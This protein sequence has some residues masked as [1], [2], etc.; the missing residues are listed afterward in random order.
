MA[1]NSELVARAE[2]LE[3]KQKF[4][5][6]AELY[7]EA[8]MKE[9]AAGAYEKG[10]DYRRAEKIYDEIGKTEDAERCREKYRKSTETW[11]DEQKS[12]QQEFGNPY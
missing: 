11:E 10:F 6:A 3:S 12:F 1:E 9:K 7:M 8:G 4:G 2:K 5:K